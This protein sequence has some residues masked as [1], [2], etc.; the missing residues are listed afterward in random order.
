MNMLHKIFIIIFGIITL[1]SCSSEHDQTSSPA[2]T[3]QQIAD[4]VFLDGYVYTADANRTIAQAIATKDNKIIFLGEN[5]S[6]NK[7]IGKITTVHHLDGKMIMPGLHDAHIHPLDIIDIDTCDLQSE[8]VSL[9]DMVPLLKDCIER[10]QLASGEWLIVAQW[11]FSLGNSPSKKFPTMRIALDAS[12]RAALFRRRRPNPAASIG[13]SGPAVRG[14]SCRGGPRCGD[15]RNDPHARLRL[16]SPRRI[17]CNA[18]RDVRDGRTLVDFAAIEAARVHSERC[19]PEHEDAA[20]IRRESADEPRANVSRS[21]AINSVAV[22]DR[23]DL[24]R[25]WIYA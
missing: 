16:V 5:E 9:N 21:Q 2:S 8:P 22:E 1:A 20:F 10:D 11:S 4:H 6:A 12:R 25:R 13:S 7:Y 3:D 15:D 24:R 17:Q 23:R 14:A 19:I 18:C